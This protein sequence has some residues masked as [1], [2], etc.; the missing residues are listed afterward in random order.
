[1]TPN[2]LISL[3][4]REKCCCL[5][6]RRQLSVRPGSQPA[7]WSSPHGSRGLSCLGMLAIGTLDSHWWQGPITTAPQRR[8]WLLSTARPSQETMDMQVGLCTAQYRMCWLSATQSTVTSAQT[9]RWF[10]LP[11]TELHSRVFVWFLVVLVDSAETYPEKWLQQISAG[12]RE[13]WKVKKKRTKTK[14]N[15][16]LNFNL[17]FWVACGTFLISTYLFS[18]QFTLTSQ[19]EMPDITRQIVL[20]VVQAQRGKKKKLLEIQ[21][22][23]LHCFIFTN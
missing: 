9:S 18:P 5:T 22:G 3:S 10:T 11:L 21:Q 6:C 15:K 1:M 2:S 16:N 7:S 4:T 19:A 17:S 23:N 8:S 13:N 12:I 20:L 14:K